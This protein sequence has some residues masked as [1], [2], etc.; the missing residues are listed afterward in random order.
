[1]D[2]SILNTLD[3]GLILAFAVIGVLLTFRILDFPDLTVEGSFPLGG[4]VIA[5]LLVSGMNPWLGIIAAVIC[6]ALAGALTGLLITALRINEIIAGIV[7]AAGMYSV[8]LLVM[9]APNVNLMG[10]DTIYSLVLGGLGVPENSLNRA[11]VT[12]VLLSVSVAALIWFLNT[13]LGLTI[14]AAGANKRMVRALGMN[15]SVSLILAMMIG[16]GFVAASGA[17]LTQAQGFADVNMGIGTLVAAA[18]SVVIGETIFG[19]RNLLVWCMGAVAGALIY[20]GL[21]NIGL[22]LGMPAFYFKGVTAILMVLALYVPTAISQYRQRHR[23]FVDEEPEPVVTTT[24][25]SSL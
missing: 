14:R 20:Q 8:N 13:D 21:L 11:G 22:R 23:P 16:N 15:T 1:M 3:Q 7:V 6:G 9:R 2:S 17:L 5:T 12:F 4:A 24:V 25:G 18:A 19:R 10:H